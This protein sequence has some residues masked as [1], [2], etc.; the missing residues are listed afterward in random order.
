MTNEA[1]L[2]QV[3]KDCLSRMDENPPTRGKK[4]DQSAL[5]RCATYIRER[6]DARRLIARIENPGNA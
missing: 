2:L 3:L 5:Y 1:E 6:E 4:G